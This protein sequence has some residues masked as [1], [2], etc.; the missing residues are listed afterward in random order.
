MRNVIRGEQ[1]VNE[2]A[3]INEIIALFI[4]NIFKY[5]FFRIRVSLFYVFLV[6]FDSKIN[7]EIEN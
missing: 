3:Q 1:P 7:T 5:L 4:E 6:N 2:N